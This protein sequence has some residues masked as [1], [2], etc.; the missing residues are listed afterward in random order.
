MSRLSAILREA[1]EDRIHFWCPACDRAHG[2]RVARPG[3]SGGWTWD[4]NVDAP[5]FSPSLLVKTTDFT[6]A[7]RATHDSWVAAG[8]PQPH[9]TCEFADVV[10]HSFVRNGMIDFLPDCTHHMACL[11]VPMIP[12]PYP[13]EAL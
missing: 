13:G 5:T 12:W 8:C 4:G 9:P 11:R 1:T 6:P 2:I 3:I 7:G 10:C